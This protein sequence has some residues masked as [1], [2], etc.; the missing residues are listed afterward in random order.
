M[1]CRIKRNYRFCLL[2]RQDF[3]RRIDVHFLISGAAYTAN[4]ESV[5]HAGNRCVM[6][7]DELKLA[8]LAKR[9]ANAILRGRNLINVP[10]FFVGASDNK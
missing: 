7:Q 9:L 3:P 8:K 5:K 2:W 10:L 6:R 4:G 1:H